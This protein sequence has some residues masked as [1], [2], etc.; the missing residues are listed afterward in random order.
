MISEQTAN[1]SHSLIGDVVF[2]ARYELNLCMQLRFMSDFL[3][4][5][6]SVCLVRCHVLHIF[7]QGTGRV[8]FSALKI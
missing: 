7:G 5:E 8:H 4:L 2:T 1:V 3:R 6:R